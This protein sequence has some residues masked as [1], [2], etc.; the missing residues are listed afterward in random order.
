MNRG[1][2]ILDGC[3]IFLLPAGRIAEQERVVR[4]RMLAQGE[5][6]HS[7]QVTVARTEVV[8]HQFFRER[9]NFPELSA[10]ALLADVQNRPR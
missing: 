2:Q 4:G 6:H 8:K 1:R 7:A 10:K 9:L 3:A 5:Q